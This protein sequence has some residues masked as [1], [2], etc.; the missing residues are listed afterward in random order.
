MQSLSPYRFSKYAYRY[1]RFAF[2]FGLL[3]ILLVAGSC[4]KIKKTTEVKL[5]H[6]LE[7]THPV[8]QAMLYLAERV[9]EKSGGKMT[10]EIYPNSQLGSERESIE[11]LQIGSIGMTKVSAAVMESFSPNFKVLGLPYI[12]RDKEH[13]FQVL[14]GEIGDEL[15]KEG[16][17]YWLRGLCYYDAGSRSFYSTKKPINTPQ[18]LRGMKIRVQASNTAFGMIKSF[19]GA[20]SPVSWGELYTALQ[21]GV[22]DGAENNSPSFFLSRH[23]EV[24]KYFSLNEHTMIPDILL[25]STV[26]WKS[27]TPQEQ[28]WL[29]EAADES[30]VV[31]REL[32]K[33]AEVDALQAIKDA[34]VTVS[35]PDKAPF[36][37]LV[38]PMYESFKNEP[39]VYALIQRIRNAGSK[40][41]AIVSVSKP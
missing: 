3:A 35:T 12:F 37:K 33:N 13:Y 22:V 28:Q 7:I 8:H 25:I 38:E 40:Q 23:Y 30:V 6:S 27:L 39:E 16:E 26:V 29:Q 24:S 41:E 14:D 32:W 2:T 21:Q 15:L 10:V 17:K 11:L 20:A 34:G 4:Q 36:A 18:D 1:S 9:K 5:A 19:G 31:Q